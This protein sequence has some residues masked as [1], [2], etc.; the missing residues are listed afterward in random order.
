MLKLTDGMKFFTN[1]S[2]FTIYVQQ[3][4]TSEQIFKNYPIKYTY[5]KIKGGV[6]VNFL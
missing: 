5:H 6:D 4:Q 3:T 1:K 2:I